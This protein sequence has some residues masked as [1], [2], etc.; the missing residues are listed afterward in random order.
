MSKNILK[1]I[2]HIQINIL[3]YERVY[4]NNVKKID[5][6]K[7]KLKKLKNYEN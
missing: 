1:K 6:L 5:E 3:Y 2:K 4:P 7:N